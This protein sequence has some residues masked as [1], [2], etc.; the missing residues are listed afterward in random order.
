LE[1]GSD[2]SGYLVSHLL[3]IVWDAVEVVEFSRKHT[4]NVHDSLSEIRR[5]VEGL[6]DKRDARRDGFVDV[7]R[8][9]MGHEARRCLRGGAQGA[10]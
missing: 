4:A 2:S 10:E 8:K 1:K 9:A 6:V 7:M 3:Y 5:L